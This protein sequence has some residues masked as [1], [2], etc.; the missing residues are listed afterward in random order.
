MLYEVVVLRI[1][2]EI[3]S[4][5]AIGLTAIDSIANSRAINRIKH[6]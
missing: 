5:K 4:V 2:C 3:Y 1:V 6:Y